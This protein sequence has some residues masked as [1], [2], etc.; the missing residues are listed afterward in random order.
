MF[1]SLKKTIFAGLGATVISGERLRAKLDELVE[2]GRISARE[3]QEMADKIM[4]EGRKEFD[5]GSAR[6]GAMLDDMLRKANFA[7]QKDLELLEERVRR[8]EGLQT[9]GPGV[10]VPPPQPRTP[11]PTSVPPQPMAGAPNVP[12]Q[13]V[14]APA[15]PVAGSQPDMPPPPGV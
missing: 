8:L 2:K 15:P 4:A 11:P 3:A 5:E 7:R 10:G 14:R 1:D 12:P 13:P 6:I 9:V